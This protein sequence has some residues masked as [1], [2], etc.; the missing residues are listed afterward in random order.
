MRLARRLFR[1]EPLE[2]LGPW[3]RGV[4]DAH[5]PTLGAGAESYHQRH[6]PGLVTAGRGNH[7][8]ALA[9]A[10]HVGNAGDLQSLAVEHQLGRAG[11]GEH[12]QRRGSADGLRLEIEREIEVDVGDPRH[13]GPGERKGVACV[14]GG[15]HRRDHRRAV[16]RARHGGA[17]G[18]GEKQGERRQEA[19][20]E[21]PRG[22]GQRTNG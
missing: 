3:R 16:G 15:Q 2:R 19:A 8:A 18:G 5:P 1:R 6:A 20:H 21:C 11:S 9:S 22:V 13:H 10:C 4:A 17:R 7:E 12:I 14:G